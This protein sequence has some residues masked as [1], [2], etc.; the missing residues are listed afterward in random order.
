MGATVN[1]EP[2]KPR[3]CS[4]Q[5]NRPN[6]ATD[7]IE[8][9]YKINVA[10][11]FLDHITTELNSQFSSLANTVSKLLCLVPS[12]MCVSQNQ[13]FSE[14]VELYHNDLPSP[15]LFDQ[16]YTRW[17][18]KFQNIA[19]KPS[20]CADAIKQCDAVSFP[21]I[22]IL[23]Q[24]A[25]TVPVTSCECERNASALRAL[26]TYLR[27]SMSVNRLTALALMH[28]HYSHIVD[29][30]EVVDLFAKLHPRRVQLSSVLL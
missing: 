12:V 10:I 16:E 15:E 18:F 28:I 6:A 23:L 1:V 7:S 13:D 30:D 17:K 11:P 27:T 21:N 8:K 26:H 22:F 24:I 2:S 14:L 19:N 20:S 25:C 3:S 29:L 9:W 4:R 5:R